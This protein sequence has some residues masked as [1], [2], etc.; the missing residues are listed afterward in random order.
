MAKN[1]EARK[2]HVRL[3]MELF[4]MQVNRG[5]YFL[6]EHPRNATS[7]AMPEVVNLA[8]QAGLEV[9]TCDMCAYRLKIVDEVGPAWRRRALGS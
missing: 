4:Q 6:Y 8:M 5:R 1:L 2:K 9:V 3:C 7:W